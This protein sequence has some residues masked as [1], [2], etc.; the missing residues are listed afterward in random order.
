MMALHWEAIVP[1]LLVE[2]GLRVP[3]MVK[4]GD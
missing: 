2:T 1:Q 3:A 4:D